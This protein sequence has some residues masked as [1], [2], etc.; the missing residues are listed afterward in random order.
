MA[1]V[2][3]AHCPPPSMSASPPH[4]VVAMELAQAPAE[5]EEEEEEAG[6]ELQGGAAAQQEMLTLLQQA[7]DVQATAQEWHHEPVHE[8]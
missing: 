1:V 5:V 2:Q 3:K 6:E 4:S 7:M 8:P